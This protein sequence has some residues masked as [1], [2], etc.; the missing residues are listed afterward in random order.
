[1]PFMDHP[2]VP[3]AAAIGRLIEEKKFE[4]LDTALESLHEADIAD[5]LQDLDSQ[6]QVLLL[7]HLGTE[8][9]A[10][11]LTEIDEFS[12]QALLQLLTDREVVSL[13]GEMPSDDAVDIIAS[14]PPDK[15]EKI[16]AMLPAEDREKLQELLE[17]EE[18]TA[19]GIME[20]E[21]LAVR[22]NSTI[23][24]AIILVRQ[25][26]DELENIQKIYVV[27]V[28]GIL[29]GALA[30]LDLV[31]HPPDTPVTEVMETK[32]ITVPVEMDQEEVAGLFGKYDEFT[33][34]VVDEANKLIGRIMVDDIIDVMEE[35]ASEDIAH[36]AGTREEEIGDPSPFRISR[37]RLPWLIGGLA[38]G[39][40]NAVLMSYYE[41]PLQTT[42]TLAFFIP[43]LMGMAGSIGIQAAV[44]VV[45]EL[46]LGEIDIYH[47][48]RRV[49]KELIVALMNGFV[50]GFLLFAIIFVWRRD[51]GLGMLLWVSLFSVM[52]VAAFIGT[53]VPLL[54]N[55]LKIDPAIATGPF[56]TVSNDILGLVIYM[57]LAT[58][59]VTHIR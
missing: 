23:S 45:R 9:A 12:G 34:P 33:L 57:S 4:L 52:L 19:G 42:V 28:K 21:N 14:L 10:D 44:V 43:L 5:L 50:L 35:E 27:D 2:Q 8:R 56:I 25:N 1:M 16:E 54:L 49:L 7:K 18:D 39:I 26:A 17:F 32:L 31:L 53:S 59:Y 11:V 20:F 48:G 38:G 51:A 41:V 29:I 55:R 6:H 58:Y 30:V 46:A 40:L 3:D 24:D 22:E 37:S 15:S 13:L 36:I 47:S